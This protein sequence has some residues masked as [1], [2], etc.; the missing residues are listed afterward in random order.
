MW[1]PRPG[2]RGLLG[3]GHGARG[4]LQSWPSGRHPAEAGLL[5]VPLWGAEEAVCRPRSCGSQAT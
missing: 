3:T 5:G 1:G 2:S 4:A